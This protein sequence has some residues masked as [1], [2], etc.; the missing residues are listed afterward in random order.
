M[1]QSLLD[2]ARFEAGEINLKLARVDLGV[3]VKK[4]VTH[5]ALQAEQ[6]DISLLVDEFLKRFNRIYKKNILGIAPECISLLQ[7]Y[8]W[9]GNI[10]ELKNV[11]QRAVLVCHGE[12]LNPE[13]LPPRFK[14]E[15]RSLPSVTFEIGASLEEVER[16]MIVRTLELN[17]NNRKRTAETLGISRRALYN[18]LVKHNID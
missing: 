18:K 13:H 5:F 14:S 2:L 8:N 6:A 10:R 11:I 17:K 9:P 15:S 12:V 1:T 3:L 4:R 16:E 7:R